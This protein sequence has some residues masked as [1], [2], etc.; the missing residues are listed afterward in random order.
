M[1]A[2]HRT[3]TLVAGTA[4]LTFTTAAAF[5]AG[6]QIE[7]GNFYG[8][9]KFGAGY[10]F[11]MGY[12]A[13]LGAADT[14][15][16]GRVYARLFGSDKNIVEGDGNAA[17]GAG[18]ANAD[19]SLTALG[20]SFSFGLPVDGV[21]ANL[22]EVSHTFFE[23]STTITVGPIPVTVTGSVTGTIGIDGEA[24][25]ADGFEAV[26]T[27]YADL[28]G[29]ASATVGIACA[30][31]GIEGE[32]SLINAEAPLSMGLDLDAAE[33]TLDGEAI[34]STLS[35]TIR[36]VANYCLGS[37][38]LDLVSWGPAAQLVIPI[39][40]YT[41]SF[42]PEAIPHDCPVGDFDGINCFVASVPEGTTP[43][44]HLG[45]YLMTTPQQARSCTLGSYDG[46]NCYVA[47]PAEGTS[48]WIYQ[49]VHLMTTPR[50]AP[51]CPIGAFDGAN[52]DVAAAPSGTSPWIYEGRHLMTTPLPGNVCPVGSFDGANCYVATAPEGT[53]PFIYAGHLMTTP[54]STPSCP[55]G[56][57][58]GAN[59]YVATAP[60][61]TSPFIYEGHL[62]TTPTLTPTCVI[63]GYDGANCLVATAIAGSMAFV[64][65][66]QYL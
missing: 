31:A 29:T 21:E 34:I 11:S 2:I 45:Q 17:I 25:W 62:M 26:V 22:Y 42:G 56:S 46:A 33:V 63:G 58:D 13:T 54:R 32:V 28:S 60:A 41:Y 55:V 47:T 48:P 10:S 53:S 50:Y 66:G 49:G 30:N 65:E 27:P 36:L 6:S 39:V 52:C 51:T 16:G 8:N 64:S 61:G 12:N 43:F 15:A 14:E 19:A 5:A 40:D 9:D 3:L 20:Q 23:L 1:R 44:V 24:G 57:F 35:G 4:A 7:K 18:Y 38:S 37:S 59:C